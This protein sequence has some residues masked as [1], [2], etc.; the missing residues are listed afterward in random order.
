MKLILKQYDFSF[1]TLTINNRLAAATSFWHFHSKC[2]KPSRV[3][4]AS[5]V[6]MQ[7]EAILHEVENATTRESDLCICHVFFS[8][9]QVPAPTSSPSCAYVI[10]YQPMSSLLVLWKQKRTDCAVYIFNSWKN[11]IK[12]WLNSKKISFSKTPIIRSNV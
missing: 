4:P 10:K 5:F 12:K 11:N 8:Q 2:F 1:L 3:C 6:W 7:T 9:C